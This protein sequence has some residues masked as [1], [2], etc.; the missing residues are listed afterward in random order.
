MQIRGLSD[1]FVQGDFVFTFDSMVAY[2][3]IEIFLEHRQFLGFAHVIDGERYFY[4]FNILPFEIHVSTAGYTF[5]K[6]L[7]A[8]VRHIWD[9]G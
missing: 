8:L 2:H 6:I 1:I 9:K 3:H 4:I 5:T 7:R